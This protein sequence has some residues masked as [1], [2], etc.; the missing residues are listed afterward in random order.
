MYGSPEAA[1]KAVEVMNYAAFVHP[2]REENVGEIHHMRMRLQDTAK[3]GNLKRGIGGIVDIEFLVQM[4]QL[5]HGGDCPQ[6]RVPGT[7]E[8]LAALH[9]AGLLSSDDFEYLDKSYRTTRTI[10]ER[11]QLMNTTAGHDL[12]TDPIERAKLARLL[13]YADP[14]KLLADC[15]QFRQENRRRF[16]RICGSA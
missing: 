15:E 11:L 12:P 3:P 14:A 8:A 16:E 1:R 9:K 4:L 10:I 6:I 7:F 13:N 2:W 5:R